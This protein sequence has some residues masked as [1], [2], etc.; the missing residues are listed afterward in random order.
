MRRCAGLAARRG[1]WTSP[2]RRVGSCVGLDGRLDLNGN[3][4]TRL[5]KSDVP[6]ANARRCAGIKT[7]VIQ[8]APADCVGVLVLRKGFAIP[9]RRIRGLIEV[10]G[11]AAIS[12]IALGAVMRPARMLR[13]SME[14][15]V[16]QT[17]LPNWKHNFKGLNG[18]I[19]VHVKES[20]LIVP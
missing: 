1:G 4:G 10:P 13:R 18:A 3:W 20:I 17:W 14:I 19:Q 9:T 12:G 8:R 2:W 5:E 11:R 6:D 7:E 16:R 15:D